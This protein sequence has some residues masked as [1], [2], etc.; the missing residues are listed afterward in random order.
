MEFNKDCHKKTTSIDCFY[1]IGSS[2]N[3]ISNLL[4]QAGFHI[5]DGCRLLDYCEGFDDRL[6]NHFALPSNVEVLQRTLRLRSPVLVRRHL[7]VTERIL[8]C[9]EPLFL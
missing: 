9:S 8:L 3:R 4:I 2:D 6:W 1:F 7:D 5:H